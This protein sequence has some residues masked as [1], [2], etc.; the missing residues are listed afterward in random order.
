MPAPA[1]SKRASY[2]AE[3]GDQL[4]DEELA[5]MALQGGTGKHID[6][7]PSEPALERPFQAQVVLADHA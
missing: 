4:T 5:F 3:E 7:N 1:A 2:G 6:C